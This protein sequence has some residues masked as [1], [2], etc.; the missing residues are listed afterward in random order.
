MAEK[1]ERERSR[2]K[3]KEEM[4]ARKDAIAEKEAK[5][6]RDRKDAQA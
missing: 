2:L 6:I 3:K 5:A 4:Q 1:E